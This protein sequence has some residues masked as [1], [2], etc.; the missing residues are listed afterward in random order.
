[1]GQDFRYALRLLRK[2]PGFAAVV[3]LTLAFGMGANTAVFSVVRGV[4]LH[5]LPYR[6]PARLVDVLDASVKD[7]NLSHT[8]ATYDD[9]EE[10][11]RHARSFEKIA[12]AT[13]ANAG[14]MLTGR[15]SA[16]GIL[17]IPVSQDFFAMLGVRAARGR[18]FE[19]NDMSGDCPVVLSDSFWRGT[20]AADPHIVGKSLEL[21]HRACIVIGVMPARFEFYPRQTNL[22]M[23]FTPADPRPRDRFLTITF[24][25]LKPGATAAQ[26]QSELAALHRQ[27]PQPDWQR[28]FAPVVHN[29]QDEFTFLAGRNLRATLVLLL[30]AVALV[31]LI[32][33]LN[34]ANLLLARSSARAREFAVRAALGSGRA[35]LVR[36]LLV[37][38]LL[39][40]AM[41]GIAGVAIAVALVKYFVHA[42]P[43][44]VP[45]GSDVTVN[46]PV[47]LFTALLTMATALVFG[48]APAWSGS[49]TDAGSG[50]R[51]AGRGAIA[52]G[53]RRLASALIAAEIS[54]SLMLLAGA[55]LLMRSVLKFGAADLGFDPDNVVA[56]KSSLPEKRYTS[57]TDQV[58]FYDDLRSRL[59]AI[60]GVEASAT[61]ANLPPYAGGSSEVEME[62]RGRG[63]LMDT[64]TVSEDYFSVLRI[65]LRRGRLFTVE[66]GPGGAP[67][68]VVSEKFASDYFPGADA[69]GRHVR[70]WGE[71]DAPWLTIVGVVATERHPELLREM[72]WH[73]S[74]ELY[75]PL[76]QQ[77][78]SSFAIAVRTHGEQAD[79]GRAMERAM[80]GIDA[81]VPVG[82]IF[83]PRESLGMYLKYPRF[84]AIV[85]D[86][87][88]ALALLLAALGL[89]GLLSQHVAQR[90]REL[91]LRM[92]LGARTRD[93]VRLVAIQGGVP[94]VAGVAV[95]M[96]ATAALTRYLSSLLFEVSPGDPLT[97]IAAP[98]ALLAAALVAMAKPA[99]TAAAVDPMVALRDE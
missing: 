8:F 34:V 10:Y 26:A 30:V 68:A 97:M 83:P 87:F 53:N 64:N 46:L 60:P 15:G 31:L 5:P 38:G 88:A 18:T 39:L 76:R 33:C 23:L 63:A 51:A 44:E 55:G 7:L 98:T 9:F 25:R 80:T 61:A 79:T 13:W 4:I 62:G 78:V 45:I 41:G 37:E 74:A 35:R 81:E 96:A 93:I 1:M 19:P 47:W 66:D 72:S 40:A 3:I 21:N 17:A 71:K 92:A 67:V 49:R 94:L 50:L 91:G 58:R 59:N 52:G 16:R 32:A 85:L 14:A 89:H 29:L 48:M 84:R 11:A 95:G 54:L 69:I 28:D 86:Q 2:S 82:E 77:P 43:I 90:T 6:D 57:S 99:L 73:A 65:A 22:W 56:T 70:A 27:I 42:N 20:L 75:R 12:F 36:Q 24:G